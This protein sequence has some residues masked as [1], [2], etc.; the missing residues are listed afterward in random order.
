MK[1]CL[2]FLIGFDDEVDENDGNNDVYG[3]YEDD[4]EDIPK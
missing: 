3:C 4:D 2:V 1:K